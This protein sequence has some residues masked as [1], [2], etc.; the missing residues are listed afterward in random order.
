MRSVL[1]RRALPAPSRARNAP[2]A[3]SGASRG[4]RTSYGGE[5]NP[6]PSGAQALVVVKSW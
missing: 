2:G 1:V 6:M 5:Q 3:T 4:G